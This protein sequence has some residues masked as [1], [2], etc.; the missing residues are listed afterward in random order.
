MARLFHDYMEEGGPFYPANFGK[1]E[2]V[3]VMRA[4]PHEGTVAPEQAM[5]VLDYEKAT[6]IAKAGGR[7][8]FGACACRHKAVHLGEESC[9]APQGVCTSFGYAADFLIRR[10]LAREASIAEVLDSLAR[11]R[12]LGLVLNADNVQKGV[13]FICHCCKCCCLALRGISAHGYANAVV[14]SNFICE[15]DLRT[16]T[17]CGL[18]ARACPIDAIK[19]GPRAIVDESLCLG[20]GVCVVK[21]APRSARLTRRGQRVIHPETTFRK[22][23]LSS[24]E[25]GTLQNQLFSDPGSLSQEFMRGVLG[26]FLGLA[27][28]KKALLSDALRS[29]FLKSLEAGARAKGDGWATEL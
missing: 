12:D 4:L 15:V 22:I 9:S 8:A 14:T 24:L 17:G 29:V 5:E 18:C 27:P 26:A 10:G 28:V 19:L 6:A 16:C 20:C 1:G 11:A 25:R 23:I 7:A 3:S 2:K 13:T 21:C